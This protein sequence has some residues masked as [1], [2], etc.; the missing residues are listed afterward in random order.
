VLCHDFRI[1]KTTCL[2]ILHD[3]L[4][5]TKLHLRWVPHA[6][7]VNQRSLILEAPYGHLIFLQLGSGATA[8]GATKMT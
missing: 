7:S 3:K 2:R 8:E 4:E 6:L 1:E 5:L